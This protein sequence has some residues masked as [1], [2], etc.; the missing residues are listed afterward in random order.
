MRA[1]NCWKCK[2]KLCVLV[3]LVRTNMQPIKVYEWLTTIK[4]TVYTKMKIMLLFTPPIAVPNCILNKNKQTKK[5]VTKQ[6]WWTL[7]STAG[8]KK[9]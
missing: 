3:E 2:M 4:G 5:F 6:F 7:T 8:P 9:Q 1:N